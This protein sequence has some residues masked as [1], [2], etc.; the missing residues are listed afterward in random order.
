MDKFEQARQEDFQR[1]ISNI[2]EQECERLGTDT[3]TLSIRLELLSCLAVSSDSPISI[4]ERYRLAMH[5]FQERK[6]VSARDLI[7]AQSFGK[8]VLSSAV[9]I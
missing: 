9:K 3:R 7:S 5:A 4:G 6:Y 2:Y 1:N 8:R